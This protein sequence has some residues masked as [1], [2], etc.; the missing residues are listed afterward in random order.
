[1]TEALLPPNVAGW[2]RSRG[3]APHAHQLAM[4]AAAQAGESAL[5][6]APTGGGKTVAGFLPS[7]IELGERPRDGLH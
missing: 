4:V 6:I 3:W 1:M 2:F 7:L 5:L